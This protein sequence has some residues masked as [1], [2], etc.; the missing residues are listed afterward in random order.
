MV[1]FYTI[2]VDPG[3]VTG[4]AVINRDCSI[5]ELTSLGF[6]RT[7]RFIEL[8]NESIIKVVIEVSPNK[9][10]WHKSGTM[11]SSINVGAYIREAVLLADGIESLL[12]PERVVRVRPQGKVNAEQFQTLTGYTGRTNQHVRDA[13]LLALRFG[14]LK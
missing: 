13:A 4:V 3:R 1:M 2:G 7:I 12:G 9:F 8:L 11:G 6:W 14:G 10:N 5:K